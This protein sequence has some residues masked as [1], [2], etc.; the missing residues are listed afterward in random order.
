MLR[1]RIPLFVLRDGG[2]LHTGAEPSR[3]DVDSCVV[4]GRDAVARMLGMLGGDLW[5]SGRSVTVCDAR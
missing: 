1:S 3:C 5:R 4:I 2:E